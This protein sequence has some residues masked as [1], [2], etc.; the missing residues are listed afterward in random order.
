MA[1]IPKEFRSSYARALIDVQANVELKDNIM[2]A[3]PKIVGE[4]FYTCIVRVECPKNTDSNVVKNMKK[5]SQAPKGV[6]A[7]P[8]VRCG[9]GFWKCIVMFDS[10]D[11]NATNLNRIRWMFGV[12]WRVNMLHGIHSS[13]CLNE[14]ENV[15]AGTV[16]SDENNVPKIGPTLTG[17]TSG[18][19]LYANITSVPS[20]KALNFHTLFK[21]GG[22]GVDVVIL[23]ESIRA[24]SD[25]I[26]NMEYMFF[27][28][29]RFSSMDGLDLML[30]ISPWSSYARA[31]I[32][33][34]VDVDLKDNIV[35]AMPKLVGEDFYTCT[36]HVE[37]EWKH[38]S[39]ACYKVFGHVYSEYP[40]NTDSDVVSN[41]KIFNTSGNKKKNV[42]PTVEVSNSNSF[43]MLN[44][45]ENEVDLVQMVR[46]QI[47]LVKW[48]ILEDLE[49][50]VVFSCSDQNECLKEWTILVSN[51]DAVHRFECV[52]NGARL[53]EPKSGWVL[54]RKLNFFLGLQIKQ[55]EDKI[56]FNQSKYIKEMLKK[57]GL[58]DSITT[59]TLMSTEIKLTKD[60][61][62]DSVDSYKYQGTTHLGSWYPKGSGIETIIYADS[63]HGVSMTAFSK[64]GLSAIATNLGTPFMLDSE[65]SDMCYVELKDNIVVAMPKLVAED[66]YMCNVRVEYEWK[67]P[68]CACCKVFVHVHAECPKNTDTDVVKNKKKPGQ[69]P[70]GVLVGPKVGFKPVKQVFRHV[71]D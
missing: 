51:K 71:P 69:A 50:L 49:C 62:A 45:D 55:M 29:K 32:E 24:I 5:P 11:G 54:T 57:F 27:L 9:G 64:D 44:S 36:V 21:L 1:D 19:S 61:E 4:D 10:D 18:M 41:L 33:V 13:A 14:E 59:K 3:M 37:Y 47:R 52:R 34:L 48:L 68:S 30:E 58:E 6:P 25:Q 28:G 67:P 63:D 26:A 16:N 70:R 7:G 20:R 56:F 53:F 2:V 15:N 40:K 8:K 39:C 17:N 35:V 31:L 38:P 42:E 22:N 46:L 60:D 66:F 23:V 43:D 12:Q 65:T